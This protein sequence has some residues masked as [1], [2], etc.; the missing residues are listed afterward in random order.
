MAHTIETLPESERT[1]EMDE[2][3]K[4]QQKKKK[5]KITCG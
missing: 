2:P 5:N 1:K 4:Q 3:E